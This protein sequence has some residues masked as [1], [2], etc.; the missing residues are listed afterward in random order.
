MRTR[1]IFTFA[2][3][4]LLM[5]VV[6]PAAA[7][8]APASTQFLTQTDYD[9]LRCRISISDPVAVRAHAEQGDEDAELLLGMMYYQPANGFP[10]DHKV[11][12][13]WLRKAADHGS[14]MAENQIGLMYDTGRAGVAHDREEARRWYIRAANHGDSV[15]AYNVA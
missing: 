3:L 14:V 10:E 4:L 9:R 2:M 15:A 5:G 6:R 11:A 1:G 8:V 12:L 13:L 7:Q